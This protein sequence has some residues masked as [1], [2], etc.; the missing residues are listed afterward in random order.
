MEVISKREVRKKNPTA[1]PF[2][3]I[4]VM[5]GENLLELLP[6]CQALQVSRAKKSHP[7]VGTISAAQLLS[8]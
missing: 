3:S 2:R 4:I 7:L 1:Q 5:Q 6:H 8:R